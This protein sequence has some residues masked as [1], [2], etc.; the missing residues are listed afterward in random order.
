MFSRIYRSTVMSV[1][2]TIAAGAIWSAQAADSTPAPGTTT[3]PQTSKAKVK[4]AKTQTYAG[5]IT[6]VDKVQKTITVTAK[7][8][9]QVFQVTSASRFTKVAKPATMDDLTVGEE[10]TVH[11]RAKADGKSE[12]VTIR[13][14]TKAAGKKKAGKSKAATTAPAAPTPTPTPE[15]SK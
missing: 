13:A 9:D 11:A 7:G 5:K 12:V 3:S 2:A 8:K 1:L 14:G 10:V 6:A 15:A 4:K